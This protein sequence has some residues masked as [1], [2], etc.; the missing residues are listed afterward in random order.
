MQLI[1]KARNINSNISKR[2]LI[3]A[4]IRSEPAIDEEMYIIY[5]NKDINNDIH[6]EINK[7]R[8]QLSG[9]SQYLNKK[10]VYNIR[11]RP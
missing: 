7:I 5:L 10:V 4:L 2:N 3:Y 11:K 9:I 1:A 8:I 6:N